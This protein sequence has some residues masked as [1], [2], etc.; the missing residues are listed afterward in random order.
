MAAE[1]IPLLDA[2]TE[3]DIYAD[4]T[5][6]GQ[7]HVNNGGVVK[8]QVVGPYGIDPRTGQPGNVCVVTIAGAQI[9]W[10]TVA[11]A[12]PNTIKVGSGGGMEHKR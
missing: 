9:G 5:V 10:T 4:D 6:T 8:F 3:V 7:V 11:D 1:P 12:G 2:S